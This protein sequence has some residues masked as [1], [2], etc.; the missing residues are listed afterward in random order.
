[1]CKLHEL[2]TWPMYFDAVLS[3]RKTFEIR[4]NDR[5][6]EPGDVLILREYLAETDEPGRYTGRELRRRIS[7][8]TDFAQQPGFVVMAIRQF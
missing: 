5:G 2:K 4:K 6:F 3:G 1:M 8:I 7:Y